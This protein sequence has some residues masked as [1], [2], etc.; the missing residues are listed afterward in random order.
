MLRFLGRTDWDCLFEIT[1]MDGSWAFSVNAGGQVR[2]WFDR[3]EGH[4]L[5]G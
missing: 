5:S 2:D 1:G 3:R 4:Y